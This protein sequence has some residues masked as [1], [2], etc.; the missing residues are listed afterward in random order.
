MPITQKK[1]TN[2]PSLKL[3]I[4]ESTRIAGIFLA[5]PVILIGIA[6][7]KIL[8]STLVIVYPT[9]KSTGIKIIKVSAGLT[10]RHRYYVNRRSVKRTNKKLKK[11]KKKTIELR[12]KIKALATRVAKE[13]GN[14]LIISGKLVSTRRINSTTK[15]GI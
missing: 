10:I 3:S 1:R 13:K 5:L 2:K 4:K 8:R 15:T 11:R 14:S 12:K 9:L 6:T 7:K